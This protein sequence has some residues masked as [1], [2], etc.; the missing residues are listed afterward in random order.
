MIEKRIESIREKIAK[1]GLDGLMVS[2]EENRR[3]L[4]GFTGED[5]QFDETAGVLF[6]TP[7]RLLLATDSRYGLQA[8]NEAPL[9]EV[10][11]YPKGL[12]REF[13]EIVKKLG[14]GRLG[15]ES[16]RMSVFLLSELEKKLEEAR[17]S[18][19]MIPMEGMAESLRV[20]KSEDEIEKIKK[21]LACAEAAFPK[22]RALLSP[23]TSEQEA[24]WLMEKAMRESGA[25]SL[26]FPVIAAAGANSALP[27][28]IPGREKIG[29]GRPLL[30]DWGARV[31][32]YCSDISRTVF[33]SGADDLF[34]RVYRT[35]YE[36]QRR[37]VSAIRPGVS[38]RE[39]DAA[40]RGFIEDSEFKGRFGH[41]L[42]HGVGLA[43]H[44][45]PRISPLKDVIL[46]PGMVFTVEPGIYIPGRGGVRIENMARVT[47]DGVEELNRLEVEAC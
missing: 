24:A 31:D 37:A 14:A 40:A 25:D 21:S 5:G 30:F 18:A 38:G 15:F 3:Y 36:A 47:E 9:F 12:A 41:G 35:V 20:I 19:R 26:S 2:V 6:I 33:M 27:H 7:D 42:G 10:L 29:K 4:S 34:K 46:E 28:A 1:K 39:V 45:E 22:T 23:G 16:V 11:E 44:E 43:V 17:V 13:P 8:E 32:G